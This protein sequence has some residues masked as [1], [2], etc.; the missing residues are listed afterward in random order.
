MQHRSKTRRIELSSRRNVLVCLAGGAASIGSV[1]IASASGKTLKV[2]CTLDSSGAEKANG[3]GLHVGASACFEALNKSGGIGSARV[4]LLQL[5]DKFNPEVAKTNA[6]ALV[7][8][9]AVVALLHPLGT[10]Q[11][12]A[13]IEAAQ[14]LAIVGPLT[15]TVGLRGKSGPNVFWVR[16]NYAQ[17]IEKLVATATVLGM[18]RIGIVHPNDPFGLPLLAAF[19]AAIARHQ[20][21][22]AVIATTPNT[23]SPDV[24]PA[25]LEI[26]RSAPQVVIMALA[27]TAPSFVKALRSA[28]AA[29]SVYGLSI[30]ASAANLTSL[31][32]FSR[33]MGFSIVVPSPFSTKFEVV[34]R[35]QV[36]MVASGQTEFSLPS[37]EGYLNAKVLAEGLRRAGPMTNRDS[38]LKA[39]AGLEAFD[40]GGVR[41]SYAG[42]RR[43][44][45]AFVDVAAVGTG[46][47]LLV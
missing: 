5:D 46:G 40:L 29:S 9:P 28:G 11:T 38:V 15:G 7:A 26:A 36:D 47:R 6:L 31:A 43:E 42:G 4:E 19:K 39:L 37:L 22:P 34:R 16:A 35:Y 20:L 8:D 24:E 45:G 21:T 1:R 3:A 13:V 14:G 27:G 12:A 41:V 23:I 25:A 2:G 30:G 10:R 18:T 17:E 33:G 44:G 32:S